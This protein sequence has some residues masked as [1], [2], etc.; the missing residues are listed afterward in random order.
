[1]KRL[2]VA[3]VTL[4]LIGACRNYRF[5]DHISVQDGLIPAD[6]YATYGRNQAIAVAIGREF[7]RPYNSGAGAQAR[8]AME[9]AR[10]FP[11]VVNIQ[12]D[13]IGYR[14]TVQFKNGWRVGVVPI[15]DG[16]T[17]DETKIPS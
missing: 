13:T 6:E 16:R 9:Y 7:A 1:M 3:A 14:L 12:A 11:D 17:G 8:V 2:A 5:Q 10:K 4:L 15:N